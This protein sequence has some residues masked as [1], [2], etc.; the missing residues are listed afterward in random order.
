MNERRMTILRI[1]LSSFIL[2]IVTAAAG[3]AG[4]EAGLQSAWA[5]ANASPVPSAHLANVHDTPMLQERYPRYQVMPSDILAISFPLIPEIQTVSVTVQP[6]G[7]INL[8]NGVGAMYVKGFTIPQIVDALTKTYSKTMHNP[9]VNVDI[10]N[11]QPPQFTV[12][13]QVGKPGQYPLRVDTTISEGIAVA[14][15]FLP[16]AKTQVFL[17]HRVSSDWVEVKKVNLKDLLNGRNI[18]E[19][20][21]LQA[22]DMIFVPDKFIANFRKY[23]PYSLGTAVGWNGNL[24]LTQ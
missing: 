7:F 17:F 10:T 22:G 12:N 4:C 11:F 2:A 1:Q 6:D 24:L 21:H 15:G 20:A 16:T 18:H 3:A 5:Q 19:D 23:V 13:G 14:G 8:P 9:I